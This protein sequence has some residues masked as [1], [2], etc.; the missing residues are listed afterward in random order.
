MIACDSWSDLIHQVPPRN[1][2][3]KHTRSFT[4][5]IGAKFGKVK[6]DAVDTLA[7]NIDTKSFPSLMNSP[8][9]YDTEFDNR[10]SESHDCLS[11]L[12]GGQISKEIFWLRRKSEFKERVGFW[13]DI[14][15]HNWKYFFWGLY[16]DIKPT[17]LPI[18]SINTFEDL[19]ICCSE[20]KDLTPNTFQMLVEEAA[21]WKSNQAE[22]INLLTNQK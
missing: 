19:R 10:R 4:N 11:E 3:E 7:F 6:Q 1:W 12:V 9:S 16:K 21:V 18:L 2:F 20:Y 22:I 13:K 15:T 5:K 17:W 8:L 14:K